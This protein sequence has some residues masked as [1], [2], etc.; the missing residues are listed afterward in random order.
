MGVASMVELSKVSLQT[1]SSQFFNVKNID[2]ADWGQGSSIQTFT[3]S[4]IYV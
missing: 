4:V 1:A 3:L 2:G